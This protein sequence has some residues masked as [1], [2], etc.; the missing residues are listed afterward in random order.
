MRVDEE[1]EGM[2]G[3]G[4]KLEGVKNCFFLYISSKCM[5]CQINVSSIK[6]LL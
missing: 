6:E 1:L 4:R 2:K 5:K 3:G